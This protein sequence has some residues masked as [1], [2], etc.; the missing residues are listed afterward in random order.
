MKVIFNLDGLDV[1]ELTLPEDA[2]LF[3]LRD[4][5]ERLTAYPDGGLKPSDVM[6]RIES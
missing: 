3:L 4:E 5:V 1:S 6:I 2:G